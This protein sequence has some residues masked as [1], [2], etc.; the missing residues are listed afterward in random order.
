[1]YTIWREILSFLNIQISKLLRLKIFFETFRES[2]AEKKY[3]TPGKTY[4]WSS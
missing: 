3:I 1:L 2:V 4:N